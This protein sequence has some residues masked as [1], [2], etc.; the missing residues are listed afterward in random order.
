MSSTHAPAHRDRTT[1][2]G[3]VLVRVLF[4]GAVLAVVAFTV[5][6]MIQLQQWMW[7]AVTVLSAVAIFVLYSTKRFV[8]GKYLFPGTFF[9][10]VFL[11]TPIILTVGYSL[12][13]FGD[14]TR[15]TKEQAIDSI[16]ANSVQQTEDSTWYNMAVGTKGDPVEGP[17][18]LFLVDPETGTVHRGDETT[19]LEEVPADE[20]TVTSGFVTE[21]EGYTI[22]DARQVNAAYDALQQLAVP[23]SDTSAVRVQGANQAFEGTTV[24]SY[25]EATDT[26]TDSRTGEEYTV[27]KIGDTK[28]FVN[29][30][31]ERAFGQSWLQNV[32][33]NNYERL[34]TNGNIAGQFAAAFVWTLVFALGSVLATFV[35]GFALALILNDPRMRGR[36]LYRSILLMP[37]A[38]PGFISLLVWSNFYNRDFG[39]INETLGLHLDWL[40]DPT[41]AKAA[42]LLTNLWMGFPYMFIVST[43]ALQAIP[44]DMTEAARMDGASR[45]Q[46]TVKVVTPLLLVAVAPL[47]VASFAFNFNNFNAIQ[48]LTEGGPFLAGEYTRGGTDILISMIYRIAFGGSGADFGF[49]SAV[50]VVLF[51]LTG[52]LAAIQF[53]FTNI[54]EDVN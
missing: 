13:N 36:R 53:R 16:I 49:A 52:V 15:G 40:G 14:G 10:V 37:Y 24:L 20:V 42:V 47:L 9:L 26:I 32:G 46:T 2:I 18:T 3:A 44:S 48:L 6:L 31:G 33:L 41:L 27:G 1:T 54:L 28:Y 38:V 22:L 50:S 5:P 51:A 45:L 39:L 29:S 30:S 7:L 34:F 12:T 21:A 23:I 4:L 8:P 25:D 17:F 43:G 19:S 35:V 11:I